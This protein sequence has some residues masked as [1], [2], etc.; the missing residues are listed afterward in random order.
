MTFCWLLNA[1][2]FE[3]F[4]ISLHKYIVHLLKWYWYM[5]SH[6]LISLT[7]ASTC[8]WAYSV[9]LYVATKWYLQKATKRKSWMADRNLFRKCWNNT[10]IGKVFCVS[11]PPPHPPPPPKSMWHLVCKDIPCTWKYVVISI[12]AYPLF[13]FKSKNIIEQMHKFTKGGKQDR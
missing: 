5:I 11:L 3:M 7:D 9:F 2:Q 12:R 13:F 10:E 6:W 1:C 8:W 4:P